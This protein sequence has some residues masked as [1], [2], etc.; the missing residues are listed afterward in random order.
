MHGLYT[1]KATE[2]Y[3]EGCKLAELADFGEKCIIYDRTR[4]R[5]TNGF[6]WYY[7]NDC[8]FYGMHI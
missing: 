1:G 7:D 6:I 8:R 2:W 3:T 4:T 5:I